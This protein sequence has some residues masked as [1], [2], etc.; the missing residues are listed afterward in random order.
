MRPFYEKM[1]VALSNWSRRYV[2]DEDPDERRQRLQQQAS[3]EI[4]AQ[5]LYVVQLR[6]AMRATLEPKHGLEYE[7]K[8]AA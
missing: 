1:K 4:H 5:L 7:L 2:C 3:E 8:E 6:M